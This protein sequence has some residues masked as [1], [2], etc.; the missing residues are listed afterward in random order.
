MK[1]VAIIPAAGI[2]KRLPGEV[3]KQF[4]N[5]QG[6]PILAHTLGKFQHSPHI[7]DVFLVTSKKLLSFVKTEIVD[8]YNLTK[9][10]D[11]L[12]GGKE[13]QDSVYEGIKALD[14]STGIV[15][16]HD[17]VRP[18]VSVSIIEALIQRC[19]KD[20]AVILAVR[21]KDTVKTDADGTIGKTLDRNQLWLAQTPQVFKY[22][23]IKAAFEKAYAEGS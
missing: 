19:R 4:L 1:T 9:V 17:G 5:L 6:K 14:S 2:G 11:L 13:R 22:S 16:V 8:R 3:A 20:E 10:R 21:P 23:I 15:L 12:I 18:F 7:D